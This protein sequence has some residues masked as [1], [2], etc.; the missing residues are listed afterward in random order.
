MRTRTHPPSLCSLPASQGLLRCIQH[1][2]M[3]T[4]LLSHMAA[5][6]GPAYPSA[7]KCVACTLYGLSRLHPLD[8]RPLPTPLHPPV[9][10][11]M[12]L[13]S[14]LAPESTEIGYIPLIAVSLGALGFDP[15]L[16]GW[17]GVLAPLRARPPVAFTPPEDCS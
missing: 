10:A 4:G 9:A 3:L 17:A 15:G 6:L 7:L 1:S 12:S 14:R 5:A 11:L 16:E 13:A 2:N 8:A